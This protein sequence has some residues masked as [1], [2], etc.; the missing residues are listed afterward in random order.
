MDSGISQKTKPKDL[1]DGR[2][3]F[4]AKAKENIF[5]YHIKF[6]GR[7]WLGNTSIIE[8]QTCMAISRNESMTYHSHRVKHTKEKKNIESYN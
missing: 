8:L 4:I 6:R 1:Q 7:N 2:R 5:N 3:K